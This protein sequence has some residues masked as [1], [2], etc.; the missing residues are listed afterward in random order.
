MFLA[1]KNVGKYIFKKLRVTYLVKVEML[2]FCVFCFFS[3]FFLDSKHFE[4]TYI[5]AVIKVQ[6]SK[7]LVLEQ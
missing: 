7:N 6:H 4:L 2:F 3:F 1:I 5:T